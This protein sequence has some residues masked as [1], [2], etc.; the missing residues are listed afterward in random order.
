MP[1]KCSARSPRSRASISPLPSSATSA[2]PTTPCGP[3]KTASSANCPH[4]TDIA[5]IDGE[6]PR[7]ADPLERLDGPL[8]ELTRRELDVLRYLVRGESNSRIAEE[9][10]VS[11]GTVKTHVKNGPRKL[12][13]R[14]IAHEAVAGV[15]QLRNPAMDL[16]KL[17]RG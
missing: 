13:R 17:S 7:P 9:L 2:L 16:R 12:T 10:Y 8:A 5:G 14:L 3:W 6:A 11:P 4:S 1:V 15:E